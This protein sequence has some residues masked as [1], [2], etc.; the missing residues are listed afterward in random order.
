MKTITFI[1]EHIVVHCSV[2]MSRS[3]AVAKW[4]ADNKGYGLVMHLEGVGTD[5]HYN[6]HVYNTLDACVGKNMAAYYENLERMIQ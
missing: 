6:N 3:A 4:F 1:P 5:K 2:G